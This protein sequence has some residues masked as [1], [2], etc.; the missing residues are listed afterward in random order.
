MHIYSLSVKLVAKLGNICMFKNFS[1]VLDI[2][3]D[4]S[5]KAVFVC[6]DFLD[7][8]FSCLLNEEVSMNSNYQVGPQMN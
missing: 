2:L 3:Q 4:L 8:F 1:F 6:E 7:L 5:M